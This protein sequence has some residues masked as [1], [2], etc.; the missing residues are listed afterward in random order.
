MKNHLFPRYAGQTLLIVLTIMFALLS[1]L[2]FFLIQAPYAPLI[3]LGGVSAFVAFFYWVRHSE[4][5]LFFAIFVVFMPLGLI[6]STFQ[7]YLNRGATLIVVAVWLL[8]VFVRK[9][10]LNI[11]APTIF[12]GLFILWAAIS[13]LWANDT[14]AAKE[15]LQ[16]YLLRFLLFL[17][18][19]INLITSQ[20]HVD[21]LMGILAISG[22]L[23]V[24]VSL[25]VLLTQGYS[26]GTRLKI[27][28]GNEN[29]IGTQLL[30]TIPAFLWFVRPIR[31][32]SQILVFIP[33]FLIVAAIS[34]I[35]LSGSR[36]SAISL[37]VTLLA[38]LLSKHT[39]PWGLFG[40]TIVGIALVFAPLIFSTTIDRF[41][42]ETG[43]SLFGGREDIWPAAVQLIKEHLFL[44]VGIG[45][46]RYHITQYIMMMGLHLK[47]VSDISLHNPLLVIAADT[48]IPGLFFYFGIL[49]GSFYSFARCYFLSRRN[50]HQYLTPYFPLMA[51]VFLGYMASWIKGGGMENDFSY[52]LM[53]SM[54]LIPEGLSKMS[55]VQNNI[56]QK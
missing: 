9:K 29:A 23:M 53:L 54:L 14:T 36:G 39:R 4:W 52:F 32:T 7:S 35:G 16:T 34:L 18:V 6:P 26:A 17:V 25:F 20:K 46:S 3:V 30:I 43:G 22:C 37:G 12:M 42:G 48:G 27:L 45:N 56:E 44:G 8:D 51:A 24:L 40:L 50:G 2:S 1:G 19:A 5:A 38:F 49:A 55:A 10:R 11:T 31:K 21:G 47:T 15:V 41:L 13:L 28:G 33:A